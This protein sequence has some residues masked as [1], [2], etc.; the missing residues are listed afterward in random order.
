VL[1]RTMTVQQWRATGDYQYEVDYR[2]MA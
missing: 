2:Y 1:D